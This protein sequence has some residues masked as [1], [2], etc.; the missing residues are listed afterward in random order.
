[1]AKFCFG[2]GSTKYFCRQ[3]GLLDFERQE[4]IRVKLN[5]ELFLQLGGYLHENRDKIK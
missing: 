5:A 1:M 3:V 2:G 4:S